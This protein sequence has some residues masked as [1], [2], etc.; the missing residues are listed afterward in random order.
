MPAIGERKKG[1][2]PPPPVAGSTASTPASSASSTPSKKGPA[3]AVPASTTPSK[4]RASSP[5]VTSSNDEVGESVVTTPAISDMNK[6]M[7]STP[8]GKNA[9]PMPDTISESPVPTKESLLTPEVNTSVKDKNVSISGEEEEPKESSSVLSTSAK[10]SDTHTMDYTDAADIT[11]EKERDSS[12]IPRPLYIDEKEVNEKVVDVGDTVNNNNTEITSNEKHDSDMEIASSHFSKQI[13]K[14]PEE[15]L[16]STEIKVNPSLESEID[17]G[18]SGNRHEPSLQPHA[19]DLISSISSSSSVTSTGHSI[20]EQN[21]QE[22]PVMPP[23]TFLTPSPPEAVI[24]SISSD[25]TV[26]VRTPTPTPQEPAQPA[27]KKDSVVTYSGELVLFN[28][29]AACLRHRIA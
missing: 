7:T 25:A 11:P 17:I 28:P 1:P 2:A 5:V 16:L 12:D 20:N 10:T 26:I 9:A 14:E 29:Y 23:S 15:S 8:S 18:T 24:A 19:S 6:Q 22:V 13:S 4:P 3:P 21:S 27:V